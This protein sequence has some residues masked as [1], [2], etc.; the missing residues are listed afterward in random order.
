MQ[1]ATA[2]V[3][4]E[5]TNYMEQAESQY[6]EDNGAVES[7]KKEMEVVLQNWYRLL[8]MFLLCIINLLWLLKSEFS[9]KC[10]S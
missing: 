8:P 10:L 9:P 2:S 6:I 1:V 5:W 4:A 3:E 7:G